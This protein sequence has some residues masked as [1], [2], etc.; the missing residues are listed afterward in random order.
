MNKSVFK[1]LVWNAVFFVILMSG[2]FWLVLKDQDPAELVE[3]ARGVDTK[4]LLVGFGAM[5]LYFAMEAW[6][7]RN[8]LR[9]FGEKINF[10]RA[11]KHTLIGFFFAAVTPGA[12]GG[13]PIEVYYMT[14]DGISAGHGSLALLVQ[15]CGVQIAMMTLGV[16]GMFFNAGLLSGPLL[17]LVIIGL[18]VNGAALLLMWIAIFSPKLTRKI[19]N[20]VIKLIAKIGFK[21][22]LE[23]K[24]SINKSLDQYAKGSV[25][26]KKHPKEFGACIFRVFIQFS[27]YFSVPYFVY[28]AFGLSGY[29]F[30]QIFAM[31]SLI[32]MAT[33]AL[34]IPGAIGASEATF[35]DLFGMVFGTELLRS[36]TLLNRGI[37]FYALVFLTM[38]VVFVN[39]LFLG[40]KEKK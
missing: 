24:N 34:P 4:F 19:V 13:Q 27:L 20:F 29:S 28:K 9:S 26:L 35:L 8:I 33:S 30:A 22:V 36:A 37:T 5:L 40:R 3:V 25:Y 10:W 38:L 16:I 32:F 17:T 6:N 31:Q 14:K 21:K 23:Q 18:I 15:V 1:Q 39:N 12:S 2:T 11:Y 7:I